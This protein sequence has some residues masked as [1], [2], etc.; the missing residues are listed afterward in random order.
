MGAVAWIVGLI[1][2]VAFGGSAFAKLTGHPMAVDARKHLG[3][4]EGLQ[5]GIGVAELLG[6]L[7]VIIGLLSDDRALEWAGLLA[8]LG[9]IATMIGAVVYHSRAGDEPKDMAPAIVLGALS[10]LY[11][12]AIAAR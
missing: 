5:K 8:G 1:L 9:L 10:V 6:A 4:S 3:L 2:T 11:L 12:I 7:G